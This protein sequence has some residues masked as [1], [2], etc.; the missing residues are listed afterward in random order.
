MVV[1]EHSASPVASVASVV[2]GAEGVSES[3]WFVAIVN[4]R[5]EKVAAEKLTQLGYD[6][7]LPTQAEIR[8][9]R[10]GRKA[11]VDRVVMPSMVF[12]HCTERE[13]REVVKL[14]FVNRFLTDRAA[15]SPA[16]MNKPVA[17]IPEAEISRLKFML[18]QS[19]IPVAITE[20]VYSKGDKVRVIRGRLAGLEG[21]VMD[22]KASRSE[23]TVML[24]MLG[25]ATLTIETVNL[26]LVESNN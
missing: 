20:C 4:P 24:G 25:C 7:Y 23:L 26:E 5:A 19:D 1:N 3:Y 14:P 11:K 6:N 22:L 2:D 16:G 21:T 9:W 17:R 12:V 10:N 8:V 18:G 13:R 15:A